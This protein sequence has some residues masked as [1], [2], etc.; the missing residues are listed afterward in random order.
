MHLI[1]YVTERELITNLVG[2]WLFKGMLKTVSWSNN[3]YSREWGF[4]I[5]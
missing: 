1:V 5:K 3:R 4:Q 2:R